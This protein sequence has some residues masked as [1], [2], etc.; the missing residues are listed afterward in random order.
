[1][2]SLLENYLYLLTEDPEMDKLDKKYSE[3][4]KKLFKYGSGPE[5]H[6]ALSSK[7]RDIPEHEIPENHRQ[8]MKKYRNAKEEFDEI[9]KKRTEHSAWIRDGKRGPKPGSSNKNTGRSNYNRN[10]SY[11]RSKEWEQAE[12][13]YREAYRRYEESMRRSRLAQARIAKITRRIYYG[14]LLLYITYIAV[15]IYYNTLNKAHIACKKYTN[16]KYYDICVINF[17]I[18]ANK[19][20][21]ESLNNSL[22]YSKLA[23]NPE[24]YKNEIMNKINKIKN[25]NIKLQI[26]LKE[27]MM[28]ND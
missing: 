17:K 14:I 3:A 28:E 21:I 24:K 19:K 26:K 20:K 1:M 18:N 4:R 15:A 11:T 8:T 27:R 13:E 2:I 10:Y 12:K 7:Y 16:K 23:D 5:G 9:S 6:D 22:K 25:K